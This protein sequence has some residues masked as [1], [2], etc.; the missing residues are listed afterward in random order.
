LELELGVGETKEHAK[1]NPGTATRKIL[2]LHSQGAELKLL[3]I[4]LAFDP[5]IHDFNL[6]SERA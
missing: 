2:Q 4:D 6:Q 5:E 3:Y 1:Q